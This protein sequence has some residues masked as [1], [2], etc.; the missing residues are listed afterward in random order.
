[1]II[2]TKHFGEREID[3]DRLIFFEEGI[4]GFEEYKE[5]VILY[6]GDENS[7]N[8]SFCWLQS[9]EEANLVL[10][11]IDPSLFFPDY[12]PEV[13][14]ELVSRIG[15]PIE[16]DLSLFTVVVVPD[17]ISKMTTNLMAPIIINK[18]TRKAIQLI[19]EDEIY[20]IK[21]NLYEQIKASKGV[22]E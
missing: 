17:D 14:G 15:E 6:D 1:M 18:K 2:Q 21:T 11:M 5:F 4:F 13:S 10:P 7:S 12:N 9:T 19:V 8:S 3:K 22:G 16:E 20:D